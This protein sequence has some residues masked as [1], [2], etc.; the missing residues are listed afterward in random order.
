MLYQILE[1]SA[2]PIWISFV[3]TFQ[4]LILLGFDGL[5]VENYYGCHAK[6]DLVTHTHVS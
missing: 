3:L 5:V 6:F 1:K 4:M 2:R